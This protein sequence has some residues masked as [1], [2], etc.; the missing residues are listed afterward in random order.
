M[1]FS[2]FNLPLRLLLF[3][4]SFLIKKERCCGNAV[5]DG[6]EAFGFVLMVIDRHR[7]VDN[8]HRG[9]NHKPAGSV[10]QRHAILQVF[11]RS[12]SVFALTKPA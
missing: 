2:L 12:W 3:C 11:N 9:D 1:C 7:V 8:Y 5:L 10:M 6:A 4:F